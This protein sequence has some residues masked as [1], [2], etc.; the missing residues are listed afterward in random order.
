MALPSVLLGL[1]PTIV[2]KGLDLFDK[3]YESEGEKQA[4]IRQ[5]QQEVQ[6]ELL[7]AWQIEQE[8]LTKRHAND[9]TSDSWLSKNIR[10]IVLIYLM[11]LFTIAYFQTVP[12]TVM[13]LLRD[14]LMTAFAFYFGAR[15]IEKVVSVIRAHKG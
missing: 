12:T 8:Q 9:M 10:P 13:S 11:G 5:F 1:V 14:L 15:S 6:D 7:S 2:K 4:A 3:K